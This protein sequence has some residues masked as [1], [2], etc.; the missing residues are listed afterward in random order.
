MLNA[1]AATDDPSRD[2]WIAWSHLEHHPRCGEAY[3]MTALGGMGMMAICNCVHI[4]SLAFLFG[5]VSVPEFGSWIVPE[6]V[7]P[8]TVE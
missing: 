7:T 8:G 1:K 2:C 4:S 5:E 3:L 6:R